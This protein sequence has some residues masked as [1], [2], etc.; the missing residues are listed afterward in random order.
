M[1]QPK[2]NVF[3]DQVTQVQVFN[4]STGAL[5]GNFNKLQKVSFNVSVNQ[6]GVH[7]GNSGYPIYMLDGDKDSKISLEG[8]SLSL[9]LLQ[10]LTGGTFTSGSTT[11]PSTETI[12]IAATNTLVQTPV[13]LS[14]AVYFKTD[15]TPLTR[16]ASAPTAGQYSIA[17]NVLT[18]NAADVGKEAIVVYDYT[19]AGGEVI[20][21]LNNSKST[22]FKLIAHATVKQDDI[23]TTDVPIRIVAYKCQLVGSFNL[24]FQRKQA[25]TQTAELTLLDAGRTDRHVLDV[26]AVPPA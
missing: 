25:S 10:L 15:L 12:T 19:A 2:T 22:P 6:Q 16:V 8:V 5:L 7:G 17:T 24:D 11:V 23:S 18:F 20:A 4:I 14:D 26:I 13:A 1:G 21:I 3:V 9:S